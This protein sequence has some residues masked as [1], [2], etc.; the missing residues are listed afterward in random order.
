MQ[1]VQKFEDVL[2]MGTEGLVGKLVGGSTKAGQIG[3]D[4]TE[5]GGERRRNAAED[6]AGPRTAVHQDHRHRFRA[7]RGVNERESYLTLR[8]A[9]AIGA[10][11]RRGEEAG[12]TWPGT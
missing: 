12:S 5:A 2:G 6:A 11:D 8:R 7:R 9:S 1:F 3:N 10:Y 4:H